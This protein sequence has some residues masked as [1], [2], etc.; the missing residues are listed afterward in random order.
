MAERIKAL[1]KRGFGAL[2]RYGAV[3]LAVMA[4]YRL[5]RKSLEGS[6][7]RLAKKADKYISEVKELEYKPLI[8]F[9]VPVYNVLEYQLR[10][11]IESVLGQTYDNFELILVDDASTRGCVG[12]V[13]KEYENMEKVKVIYRKENGNI[14]RCTNTGIKAANGEFVAFLDCDDV[15]AKNAVFEVTRLLN[16]DPSLDFIYSDEDKIDNKGKKRS[17]PNFKPDFSPD[18]LLSF[19]YTC[20]LGVY[21]RSIL[22]EIG[23]L[24]VGVEGA[25]DYDLVLR[26]CEK[27]NRVGHIS[28]VLYHWRKRPEST[29]AK[30]YSKDYTSDAAYK[31]KTEALK[32][33]GIK[34]KVE[35]CEGTG[36]TRVVYDVPEGSL[37]SIIIPSKDN[38]EVLKRC[39]KSIVE[40]IEYKG[41]EIIVVDNGS[42]DENR[43]Q[44]SELCA[45]VGGVY[46]YEKM[47]FN[48]SK[49][50]NLGAELSKGDYLL[51]LND[52]TEVICG[53]MLE[54]MAGQAAQPHTGAVG[55]K[56]LYPQTTV[57]QHDGII[58]L[59]VGPSHALCYMDDRAVFDFGRNRLDFNY[60]AVTA[61]CLCID[62]KKFFEAEGFFEGLAV[63]YNDVDLCFKLYEKGYFNVVRNDVSL[64]HY[65]SLSRGYDTKSEEKLKRLEAERELLYKRHPALR[66]RDPYHNVNLSKNRLDFEVDYERLNKK[67][68]V[69]E[70]ADSFLS[71]SL[72]GGL[73]CITNGDIL[74]VR[75]HI[76]FLRTFLGGFWKKY[77]VLMGKDGKANAFRADRYFTPKINKTERS[78]L[79]GF[80]CGIEK[81]GLEKGVYKIGILAES[82]VLKKKKLILFDNEIEI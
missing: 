81:E 57:I 9:V 54:R 47:S 17:F 72:K 11:C 60:I 74:E 69:L 5:K 45:E 27:T 35:P 28:K 21:R 67:K 24:R 59:P 29:A 13:L 50:C 6:Y 41:Y 68:F 37:I 58:N 75:G 15:L 3:T 62:R 22:E 44:A 16:N 7:N 25:Q 34:G 4:F 36:Q 43:K 77:A 14:S 70:N 30:A 78:G 39:V 10:E 12:K 76:S 48:F 52:D 63:G 53:D 26:F 64:Y 38:F 65:E 31:L 79:E 23:G 80:C 66:G 8:S 49:M 56:L 19:M 2:E 46:H 73:D 82:P 32:R 33:R 40:K 55:A 18:T 1:F 20:H 51:F 71:G 61:A 42:N